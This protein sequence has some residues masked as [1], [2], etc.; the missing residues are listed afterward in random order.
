M[1]SKNQEKIT[2]IVKEIGK[3]DILAVPWENII[4]VYNESLVQYSEHSIAL[5]AVYELGR[6][7]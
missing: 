6:R 7:N 3:K 5:A 4:T 2:S 1:E